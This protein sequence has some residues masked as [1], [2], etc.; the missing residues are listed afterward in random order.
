MKTGGIGGR[1]SA[2]STPTVHALSPLPEIVA[3]AEGE[4]SEPDDTVFI[5]A[6]IKDACRL[7]DHYRDSTGAEVA[8][9]VAAE[10]RKNVL[11]DATSLS[12]WLEGFTRR[13]RQLP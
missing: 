9:L 12:N 1:P 5:H 2:S 4:G 3:E 7:V 6:R 11:W 8:D 10:E 13:L